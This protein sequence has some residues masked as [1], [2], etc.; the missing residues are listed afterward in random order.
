MKSYLSKL[1]FLIDE[2]IN[3]FLIEVERFPIVWTDPYPSFLEVDDSWLEDHIMTRSTKIFIE[4][5][6]FL[7]GDR[8]AVESQSRSHICWIVLKNK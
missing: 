4:P 1:V 2:Y 7:V 3:N 6:K 8:I 5:E